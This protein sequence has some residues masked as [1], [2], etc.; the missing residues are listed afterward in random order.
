MVVLKVLLMLML[1]HWWRT[2][3]RAMTT[4]PSEVTCLYHCPFSNCIPVFGRMECWFS[5]F[6]WGPFCLSVTVVLV[7]C[8]TLL[9]F[10][11]LKLE[12]HQ[13]GLLEELEMVSC[14]LGSYHEVH[15]AEWSV[16]NPKGLAN[17]YRALPGAL[18]DV[19]QFNSIQFN[20]IVQWSHSYTITCHKGF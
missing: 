14:Y 6:G 10:Q 3:Q 17:N 18:L 8:T 19:R 15:E 12:E 11:L 7:L 9:P 20:S 1:V 5:L 2:D 13:I 4:A 16:F